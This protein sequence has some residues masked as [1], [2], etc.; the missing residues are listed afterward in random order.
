[1][2]EDNLSVLIRGKSLSNTG[3]LLQFSK[4]GFQSGTKMAGKW[5]FHLS[6][7][8]AFEKTGIFTNKMDYFSGLFGS[9]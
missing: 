9:V 1:M 3:V 8:V 2:K 6:F 7:F 4:Y 5:F